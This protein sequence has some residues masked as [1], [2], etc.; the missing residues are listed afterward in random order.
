MEQL[1]IWIL[2][3]AVTSLLL[4]LGEALV[5]QKGIQRVLRLTGGVLLIVVLLG[6]LGKISGG[7]K[8]LSLKDY[9]S[10]IASREEELREDQEEN[11][12]A[13]IESQLDEYIWDKAQAM[14]LNV[15]ITVST[16]KSSGGIALPDRVAI[17]GP[18]NAEFSQWLEEEMG[19]DAEHQ[20]WQ[21]E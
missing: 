13:I 2:G 7:W 18:Y 21:E 1:R 17:E 11:L 6:P 12:S 16:R 5:T 3:I 10:Q 9:R 4:G 8:G 15:T 20:I 14:G 19:V